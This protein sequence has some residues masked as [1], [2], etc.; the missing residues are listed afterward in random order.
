MIVP[1][2][3]YRSVLRPSIT[4]RYTQ[5]SKKRQIF[6]L[7]GAHQHGAVQVFVAALAGGFRYELAGVAGGCVQGVILFAGMFSAQGVR[8]A[9]LHAL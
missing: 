6:P 4:S 7:N 5:P 9:V 3:I 8:G 2:P 1:E